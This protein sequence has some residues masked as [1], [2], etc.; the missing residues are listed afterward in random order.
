MAINTQEIV[1][2][3]SNL[4]VQLKAMARASAFPID[5]YEVWYS[6][7]EAEEYAKNNPTAYVGQT[8]KVLEENIL[9]V[10]VIADTNGTLIQLADNADLEEAIATIPE[11]E[12]IPE[13]DILALFN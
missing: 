12:A 1:N 9:T 2:N 10:Y 6:K 4:I 7:T 8:L 13:A 11:V 3:S 5:K